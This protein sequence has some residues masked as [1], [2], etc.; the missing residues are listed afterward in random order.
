DPDVVAW[1]RSDAP[2]PDTA[3]RR[4]AAVSALAARDKAIAMLRARG[5]IVVDLPPDDLAIGVAEAYLRVK[6]TGRL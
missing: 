1:A 4:A 5:A 3:F 2:D 6:A